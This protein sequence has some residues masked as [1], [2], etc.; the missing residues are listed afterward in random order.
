[1]NVF[2]DQPKAYR[3]RQCRLEMA[4]LDYAQNG[5]V[6]GVFGWLL[7]PGKVILERYQ[8]KSVLGKGG[9]GAAYLV[10][11][12]QLNG[13]RRA[14]KEVP[15]PLFD[16]YETAL[17]SR[18]EHPAIPDILD[19]QTVDGMVYQVLKFG[20]NRTL[21][22]ERRRY[23]DGRI[24]QDKLLPLMRQLCDVLVYLH[25]Q[26]PPVIHRDLKPSNVLLDENERIML[27]DFGIAKEA[28][29]ENRTRSLA[30]A[31]SS[32]YSP[33]E[34]FSNTG[35]DQRSDVYA[36]GATFYALLTGQ[37]P[38]NAYDLVSGKAALELPSESVPEVLPEVEDAIMQA[39]SLNM[40]HRQQTMEA[41]GAALDGLD[42]AVVSRPLRSETQALPTQLASRPTYN[43][44]AA[45]TGLKIPTGRNTAFS[46]VSTPLTAAVPTQPRHGMMPWVGGVA[47]VIG[48]LVVG[49]YFLP[50]RTPVE[51]PTDTA[52]PVVQPTPAQPT[53]VPVVS[54]P[55]PPPPATA[56]QPPLLPGPA[57]S[58]I[59]TPP[60][61]PSIAE[62]MIKEK[63]KEEQRP[64]KPSTK[65]IAQAPKAKHK[66]RHSESAPRSES[67]ARRE[68]SPAGT[69]GSSGCSLHDMSMGR[70]Y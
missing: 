42:P 38:P 4:H 5:S 39:L 62:E 17:L 18:L 64:S 6:R 15:V 7:A 1:M 16:E 51:P 29:G 55:A 66:T 33:P 12:V 28:L 41:F 20:G 25:A 21:E 10:D 63:V 36:F 35:T 47:V 9:F 14:L 67:R 56:P 26:N 13:R 57:A 19:R 69:G 32:G 3:C 49:A 65:P 30:Q 11:D 68:R 23:P 27:V 70:C 31:T 46:T 34:Q 59:Q 53:H 2:A 43:S 52:Q 54:Q 45:S 60:A 48:I 40:N 8:V 22:E 58:P 50:G 44:R 61:H 37:V 24:P